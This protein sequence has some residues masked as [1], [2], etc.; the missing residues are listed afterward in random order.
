[1]VGLAC[2]DN[3]HGQP[4]RKRTENG[5]RGI[6]VLPGWKSFAQKSPGLPYE[7]MSV[8]PYCW[9]LS[10]TLLNPT[11]ASQIQ[12]FAWAKDSMRVSRNAARTDGMGQGTYVSVLG[13]PR[14]NPHG[15]P[16]VVPVHNALLEAPL[17]VALCKHL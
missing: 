2:I 10:R 12:A 9:K 5:T 3:V 15:E 16:V 11:F 17:A 13:S 7:V 4:T 1:M 14:V 8:N 6:D